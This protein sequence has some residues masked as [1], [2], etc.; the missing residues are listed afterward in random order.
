MIDRLR[1]VLDDL[2]YPLS[3]DD[4]LDVLLLARVMD[5]A[6]TGDEDAPSPDPTPAVDAGPLAEDTGEDD[7]DEQDL[8]P[9]D[10]KP[11]PT[12]PAGGQRRFLFP[13]GG[14]I[15]PPVGTGARAVR[16]PGP[17]A[18]P[19]A[20]SLARS[21]RPLREHRDHPHRKVV[22]VEATLRLTAETGTFDVVL[23][24]ERELRHSAL[25]L[26]DNSLSM[27]VWRSLVPE[28]SGLLAR[29]G[30][31]RTVHTSGFSP[32]KP[33]P[34]HHGNAA[35]ASVIF[36]LTDGVHPCWTSAATAGAVAAWGARGP[37]AVINPLPRRLWRATRFQPQPQMV[38]ASQRFPAMHQLLMLDPLT[39]ER[40]E[41]STGD[42]LSLPVLALSPA[43]MAS[44]T[45]LLTGPAVPR[46]VEAA[47]L[48][49][50]G[51]DGTE[52]GA[53]V[54][55][56]EPPERLIDV[57]RGSFS[58]QA[59]RLAVRLSALG[60]PLSPLLIQIVRGAT[61]PEAT[62][63]HVAEVLLGGLLERVDDE[64]TLEEVPESL[65]RDGLYAFRPGVRELLSSA[66][67]R[68]Q[69][70]E[71]TKAVGRALEPYLGRLP[72]F[73]ALVADSSGT[74]GLPDGASPFAVMTD[75]A[76]REE[77]GGGQ[78]SGAGTQAEVRKMSGAFGG[79]LLR[80]SAS[81]VAADAR[82]GSLV[83]LLIDS[84]AQTLGHRPAPSQFRA[85]ERGLPSLA[86]CL[87]DA[88]LP[89]VEMLVEFA[90]PMSSG[91]VD[92]ILAGLDPLRATPSYMLIELKQW[93]S[94][95]RDGSDTGLCF[96]DAGASLVLDPLDQVR[97][98][99]DYLV[100]FN[101]VLARNPERVSTAVYLPNATEFGVHGLRDD[102]GQE[103][104]RL[105]TGESRR[106]FITYLRSR[107]GGGR[108]GEEAADE[109][110]LGKVLPSA[111]LTAVAAQ[112]VRSQGQFVLLDQQEVASR[113]V[114]NAVRRAR[115]SDHK[116][117]VVI[118]GRPGTGKSMIAL[119]L[120][121][122]LHRQG[123]PALHATGS[124]SFTQT[125]RRVVGRRRPEVQRLFRYFNSFME[126]PAN[127]LGVLICD[128]AHRIRETSATRYTRPSSLTGRPQIDELIDVAK[129]S[130]FLLDE[131]QVV[132][133]G[134]I[135]SVAEIVRVA[136][137][138][139]VPVRV[140]SLD[141]QFRC[142]GSEAYLHWTARLAGLEPGGPA[143]WEPDGRMQLLVADSPQNMEAF[144]KDRR[145]E[146]YGA[147][148]TA[149]Y[150]W[151]WSA[152][153]KPGEAL[154]LDVVIGNWARAWN[155]R[156]DRSV[157]GAPPGALW[158]TDP[159]GFGQV[160]SIYTAQGFEFD[161]SGVVIGPDLMWRGD[162]F[163]TDRTSSRDPSLRNA[164]D[165]EA[166]RMI[167][168]A[169][170]VLLTRSMVGTVIYSTDAETRAKLLELGGRALGAQHHR[171]EEDERPKTVQPDE[172]TA[173]NTRTGSAGV[174]P[175]SRSGWDTYPALGDLFPWGTPGMAAH[176]NWVVSP[177]RQVLERRWNQLVGEEDPEVRAELFRPTRDS[178]IEKVRNT[179]PGRAAHPVPISREDSTRP[180]VVRIGMRSFDRQWL[181]ADERVIDR[182]RPG[183]W[184]AL[185]PSQIFL[186]Q[187]SASGPPLRSG[188]ALVATSLL[189]DMHHFGGRGGR[190]HPVLH[191]DGAD[192]VP[193][194]LLPVLSYL[195]RPHD[196]RASD[197]AAYVMAVTA[198][199]GFT[200][201]FQDE[202]ITPEVRIP[203]TR[204]P[205]F[206]E[207]AVRLGE[208]VLW[209]STYGDVCFDSASGRP[210]K[211]IAYRPGDD[212]QVRCLEPVGDDVPDEMRYD[213]LTRTIRVG[214]GV[215][216]PVPDAVWSYGVG[217][218][219]ILRRWFGYRRERP[220]GRRS[221]P[222]DDIHVTHW[223]DEWSAE[224][225]DLLTLLCRLTE[226]AEAQEG[227]L[228]GILAGPVVTEADLTEAG[229]LP[230][231]AKA[232]R[233]H[234]PVP[235]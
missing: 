142:G 46:L 223:P 29:S 128:E 123:V 165:E 88:G 212:R 16:L 27:R 161:W 72:D 155:L 2:G 203:L 175:A 156:G 79:A 35:A 225:I 226:L 33:N 34:P 178:S 173:R 139:G 80:A 45:Q 28:I 153:P 188:P 15:G 176:R 110:L 137:N 9:T 221:S 199:P 132:R 91:R 134:E 227:L 31:F 74:S 93:T 37:I 62:S 162:R 43:S 217:G 107:F 56:A 230:V 133:P 65:R 121:G 48:E 198:H 189:P 172:R 194:P 220:T 63:A 233:D 103:E 36:L 17:R 108:S 205:K 22:D 66:L 32:Q 141:S 76:E 68:A 179:L 169:Y 182:P 157:S 166:D 119:H 106:E 206:W 115:R 4:F 42:G 131:W 89:E 235:G 124:Q 109:L 13:G 184:A 218:M 159:A 185:R 138:K 222:L 181:I 83:T 207:M 213:A 113:T 234:P 231:D 127:S 90:L 94:A 118:T 214:Q 84:Y 130:V 111:R 40:M 105:F 99:R 136:E 183:L 171:T 164:T 147:R 112:E 219:N 168:N 129:V 177:S 215:F 152:E 125:L 197:L 195:L 211:S 174:V 210:P 47:T 120:L 73:S 85:W 78:T 77:T 160:G 6:R 52:A 59:Y 64:R 1:R 150:C 87:V 3:S 196:I 232:R 75:P 145:S 82:S 102:D 54:P 193:P 201:R 53:A 38:R 190:V 104:G 70:Q 30:N 57:F 140:V 14:N 143:R 122:E 116:E 158:A 20:H 25:L 202:L 92:V 97:R 41:R 154:P 135:G 200:E 23:K 208:E 209:A 151:P 216:G 229:V 192:N 21:L 98:Y 100:Q 50:L 71:I 11:A 167:R 95:E 44:W 5:K 148:M 24:P 180:D 51:A 10:A 69:S 101:S 7:N 96:V 204:D 86:D 149:G 49:S 61:V 146:G 114:L 58:P 55:A 186:N 163:V 144:L 224:L 60:P 126:E 18:L 228:R 26:V 117:V 81:A 39:G 12:R 170:R 187:P 191:S 19:G 8:D 67:S